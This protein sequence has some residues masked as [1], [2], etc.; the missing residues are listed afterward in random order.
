MAS[1]CTLVVKIEFKQLLPK[2][3]GNGGFWLLGNEM[4]LNVGVSW[5]AL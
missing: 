3:L 5:V 2:L 1:L 4:F